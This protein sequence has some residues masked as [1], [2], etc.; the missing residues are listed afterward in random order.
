MLVGSSVER[1]MFVGGCF[2]LLLLVFCVPNA[3]N[4]NSLG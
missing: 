3:L 4:S 1:L 2:L